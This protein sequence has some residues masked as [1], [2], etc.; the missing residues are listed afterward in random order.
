MKKQLFGLVKKLLGFG[1]QP[2][3]E[4]EKAP[5][6]SGARREI[7]EP[8]RGAAP[9]REEVAPAPTF[10][11]AE[12]A[13]PLGLKLSTDAPFG[14]TRHEVTRPVDEA[15]LDLDL[16][17]VEDRE[18]AWSALLAARLV[19]DTTLAGWTPE[20]EREQTPEQFF[21]KH[22][23]PSPHGE[24]YPW[25]VPARTRELWEE[26]MGQE[27]L[28]APIAGTELVALYVLEVGTHQHVLSKEDRDRLAIKDPIGDARRA[29]FYQSYK[30]KPS[31]ERRVDGACL[32][33]YHTREG[34]GA[35]R[36]LLLPDY[37][38]DASKK[39]GHFIIASRDHLLIS[40]PE[41]SAREDRERALAHLESWAEELRLEAKFPMLAPAVDLPPITGMA[42][43]E[44]S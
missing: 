36:A 22:E 18:R 31:E 6:E 4:D 14:V 24:R 17:D 28:W 16:Q 41:S 38:Y 32:R 40:E 11:L 19:I 34:L 39:G 23:V 15:L 26:A 30:V 10:A 8:T 20:R 37:D 3:V 7:R 13:R 21:Q 43:D 35:A 5:D 29:L 12:L 42:S 2:R 44:E 27:A 1:R 25:V 33:L 9:P